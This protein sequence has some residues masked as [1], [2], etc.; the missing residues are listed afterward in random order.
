MTPGHEYPYAPDTPGAEHV[1]AATAAA[2]WS[3]FYGDSPPIRVRNGGSIH[4]RTDLG[5][6][7]AGGRA[8]RQ[9]HSWAQSVRTLEVRIRTGGE[10]VTLIG[11]FVRITYRAGRQ[12]RHVVVTARQLCGILW[13]GGVYIAPDTATVVDR[14]TEL[15]LDKGQ[16]TTLLRVVV[17]RYAGD[18]SAQ[19]HVI[20]GGAVTRVDIYPRALVPSARRR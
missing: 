5:R 11:R 16:A 4:V 7:I 18:S 14:G 2:S 6:F 12:V 3:T 1:E 8:W 10:P 20:E 19:V 15:V 13:K 17:G 9:E